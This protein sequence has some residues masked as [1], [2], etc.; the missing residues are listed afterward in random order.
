MAATD[1]NPISD[2]LKLFILTR[3]TADLNDVGTVAETYISSN[4]KLIAKAALGVET[5]AFDRT[6]LKEGVLKQFINSKVHAELHANPKLLDKIHQVASKIVDELTTEECSKAI[7]NAISY[8]IRD[9]LA[10]MAGSLVEAHVQ[11]KKEELELTVKVE[12]DRL[13]ATE[14]KSILDKASKQRR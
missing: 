11:A 12:V 7:E 8:Q 2:P 1:S 5:S 13:F 4:V 10:K 14:M 3:L 6:E 9:A